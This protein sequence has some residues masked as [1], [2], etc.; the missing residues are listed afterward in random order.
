[1]ASEPVVLDAAPPAAPR[2]ADEA[3]VRG[4]ARRDR[5]LGVSSFAVMLALWVAIT[6][7][8]LW[9]PLVNP[10]FLPSPVTVLDPLLWEGAE[11]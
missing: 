6:G 5:W 4:T 3:V 2:G 7:S 10:T 8:G 9:P 11:E 1:M